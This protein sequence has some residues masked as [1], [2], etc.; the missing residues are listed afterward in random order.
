MTMVSIRGVVRGKTVVLAEDVQLPDGLEVEVLVPDDVR[1]AVDEEG[2]IERFKQKLLQD[3]LI[4]EIRVR[5]QGSPG[6]DRA[7]IRVKGKPISETI[8]EERR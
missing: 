5:P 7:P 4:S 6:E 1:P 2:L 8:I 3:G